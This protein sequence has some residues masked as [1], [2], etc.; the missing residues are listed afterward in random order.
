MPKATYLSSPRLPRR[1]NLGMRGEGHE[2][3]TPTR[4]IKDRPL[5]IMMRILYTLYAL[6]LIIRLALLCDAHT[7]EYRLICKNRN[8]SIHVY[9]QNCFE[10]V[11]L[12]KVI[13]YEHLLKLF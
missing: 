6:V 1:G 9:L 4:P 5:L 2:L 10:Y 3:S 12:E 7:H 11:P 13:A 8:T